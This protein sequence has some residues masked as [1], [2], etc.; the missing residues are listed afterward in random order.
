MSITAVIPALNEEKNI[1][2]CIKSVLWCDK[3]IVMWMGSD[4]TG[5]I[6]KEMGADVILLTK[7]SFARASKDKDD[8]RQVQKNINWA[9]DHSTTDWMLRIDADEVVTAELKNEIIS[10]LKSQIPN[11]KS[12]INSNLK[13][14]NSKLIENLKLKIENSPQSGVVAFGIP[15]SQFFCGGFLNGGDWAYDRLIRLFKPKYCRYEPIVAVHEQ[16]K[17][18]GKICYLKNKLLHFS[19]PTLKDAIDKFQKYTDVEIQDIHISKISAFYKMIFN[20][21]YVFLRWM[22]WH[23]GYCDGFKGILA[24]AMRGWYEFLLY[25]K[26]LSKQHKK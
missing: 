18:N 22:I 9:I 26:F 2:R 11:P 6:A 1:E 23:H 15:R 4:R 17:V 21:I 8:F 3:V 14:K 24:G 12:Q 25:S 10:I 19:H 13:F 7:P 16:F 5:K 20:P